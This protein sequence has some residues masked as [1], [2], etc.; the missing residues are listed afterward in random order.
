MLSKQIVW[1]M[2][3]INLSPTQLDVVQETLK[4]SQQV[5]K[6]FNET[7]AIV[8]Y[9][10]ALAKQALEIHDKEFPKF[11]YVFI[12]FRPFHINMTFFFACFGYI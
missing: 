2:E 1:Y 4:R 6:E 11:D 7:F 10:L 3:N 8:H 5:A 12:C 9:D